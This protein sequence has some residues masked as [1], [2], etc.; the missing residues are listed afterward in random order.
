MASALW[1]TLQRAEKVAPTNVVNGDLQITTIEDNGASSTE[2]VG[3][4][5]PASVPRERPRFAPLEQ[6]SFPSDN[7]DL[8]GDLDEMP[9][10]VTPPP[11]APRDTSRNGRPRKFMTNAERQKAYRERQAAKNAQ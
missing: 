10:N 8:V 9:S 7:M 11:R 5:P 6:Q 2:Y 1:K 3:V 4:T